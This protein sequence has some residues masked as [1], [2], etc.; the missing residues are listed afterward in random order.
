MAG[1][2]GF[3][4]LRFFVPDAALLKPPLG[5]QSLGSL[6]FV[7][8]GCV[9]KGALRPIFNLGSVPGFLG[10]DGQV[11]ANIKVVWGNFCGRQKCFAAQAVIFI[12]LQVDQTHAQEGVC[13]NRAPADLLLGS[14]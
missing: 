14:I 5:Q 3:D 8:G 12:E 9:L 2:K 1:D 11:K 10:T 7:C 13:A 4:V 6:L